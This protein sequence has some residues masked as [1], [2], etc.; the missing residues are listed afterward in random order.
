MKQLLVCLSLATLLTSCGGDK[1]D[2]RSEATPA[3]AV[4]PS[5]VAAIE[6]AKGM[7][8]LA[9][10]GISPD[11]EHSVDYDIIDK[12]QAGISRH[13][14]LIDVLAGDMPSAIERMDALLVAQG[15]AKQKE[16][17]NDG[18]VDQIFIKQGVPTMV[19][20]MQPV[21]KGPKLK[22]PNAVGSIHIMWNIWGTP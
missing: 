15:Y 1:T 21:D 11:F 10:L 4:A 14:V 20:L 17:S 8:V 7:D 19:L 2:A 16:T 6:A 18:R 9:K 3:P 5:P 13:R 12:N 22:N